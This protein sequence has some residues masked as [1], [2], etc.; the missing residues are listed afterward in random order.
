MK[1]L[2][3]ISRDYWWPQIGRHVGSFTRTCEECLRNKVIRRRPIGELNPIRPPEGQWERVSVDFIVEL[4]D[5]HG[6]DAIMVVV[7][8]VTKLPHFIPTNTTVSSEGAARLYYQ[9]VWKLHGLPLEWL[10][11]RGSVFISEFMKELNCLLGI[12]TSASTAYHPQSDGQTERGQPGTRDVPPDVLQPQPERL[13]ELLPSAEF[14]VRKP[15]PCL[16]PSHS[17]RRGYGRNPRMGFEPNVDVADEDAEAFRDRMQE[18]LEE[19]KAAL[20]KAQDEYAQ[21]YN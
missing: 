13:D 9:H 16:N 14:A 20:V 5:S 17:L 21:Y 10:H 6:F 12:K 18:G 19:A 2:E 8:S 4:P 15:R 7:D 3:L 1:T 11:N